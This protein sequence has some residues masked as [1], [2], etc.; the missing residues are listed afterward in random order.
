MEIDWNKNPLIP[1]I[2]QDHETSQVLMLAY[3]NKEAY[4]LTVNTGYAHYFS[5]SNSVSGK[6]E[7]VHIIHKR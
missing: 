7:R 4:E 5:R 3:M 6:K 2:A 1:A